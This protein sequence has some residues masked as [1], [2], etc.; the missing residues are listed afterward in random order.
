[1]IILLFCFLYNVTIT[2]VSDYFVLDQGLTDVSRNRPWIS[3]STRYVCVSWY[4][5]SQSYIFLTS[6]SLWMVFGS[7]SLTKYNRNAYT[8]E[9]ISLTDPNINQRSDFVPC[10]TKRLEQKRVILVRAPPHLG[11]TS[12]A[13]LLE[14][15]LIVNS[16]K[17]L[18][19][20]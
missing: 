2:F 8:A 20:I 15:H 10:L 9:G 17:L 3:A 6:T 16:S 4:F 18:R 1:M 11:K 5:E 19:V 13:Q 12:L 7:T 14:N